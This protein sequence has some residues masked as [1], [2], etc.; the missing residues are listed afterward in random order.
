M[1]IEDLVNVQITRESTFP[2]LPGFGTPMLLGVH[3]HFLE[4]L[5]YYSRA[6]EMLAD[7]FTAGDQLYKDAVAL[8][9]QTPRPVRFAVG[10]GAARQAQVD[11]VIVGG[12][13]DGTYTIT[14]N[15]TPFSF[16]AA[17]NTQND[18]R[19]GLVAAVN[20][21]TEPVTA[22]ASVL[23][24][25]LTLTADVAG[26]PF[27]ATL[28][29]EP[30][31]TIS[32]TVPNVGIAE[33]IAAIQTEQPDW[34]ALLIEERTTPEI[35]L[36]AA[37]IEP[38]T[39]LFF[40]QT[41][42]AA[43]RDTTYTLGG[44]DVGAKLFDAGYV[45]TTLWWKSDDTESLAAALVGR[46][47]PGIPGSQTA[48]G[49]NIAGVTPDAYTTT[50]LNNLRARSA[51]GFRV[52]AGLRITFDG[53][54]S[55]DEYIDVVHGI[56]HLQQLIQ[57]NVLTRLANSPKVDFTQAGINLFAGDVRTALGQKVSD[58]L[59]AESRR[60]NGKDTTPAYT[61]TPPLLNDIPLADRKARRIPATNPITFEAELS[62]AIQS[63][64][65]SGTI[66]V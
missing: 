26:I 4:R 21:G 9:S 61:V 50:Q 20:G 27:S 58:K 25:R 60:I 46:Y 15:A 5:R 31:F 14:L 37:T 40:A 6:S 7:G 64:N 41:S 3:T 55:G 30:S 17:S 28:N 2:S 53:K 8:M 49:K 33:D 51:N 66:S 52:E 56:D 62:G 57:V 48:F 38:L 35:L 18:I 39:K 43:V 59:I 32:T 63:V 24:G 45:R 16:V 11:L 44:T 34:Y 65:I 36:A 10:R 42:D 22:A 54:V 23:T 47:L 29:V 19:D 12:A 1:P 13:T